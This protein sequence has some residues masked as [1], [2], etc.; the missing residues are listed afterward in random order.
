MKKQ[1]TI[2]LV[3]LGVWVCS[4]VGGV[5]RLKGVYEVFGLF[6]AQAGFALGAEEL[7]GFD[8]AALADVLE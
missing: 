2:W 7:D 8:L 1:F 3:V 4:A 6:Q 5:M